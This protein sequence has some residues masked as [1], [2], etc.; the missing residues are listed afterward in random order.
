MVIFQLLLVIFLVLLNGFFVASEFA[1]VAI[2]KTRI[3]ELVKKGHTS[4]KLV[5][6]AINDL[7]SYISATQLGITLA[8]LALGWIGEPAIARFLEPLI[9]FLPKDAAFITAHTLAVIIAFSFI[10]FL[11]IVLG[12]LAPK[13]IALQSAEK[14]SLVIVTPLMIFTRIFKP[15]IWLLN[16]AGSLVLKIFGFSAPSGH[17]LVHSE[18]EIKIILSQSTE[19]GILEKQELEMIHKVL[20]LGDIPVR[21]IMIPRTEIKAI[22]AEITIKEFKKLAGKD[23]LSRYPIYKGTIDTIIGYIHE[24]DIY[25]FKSDRRDLS[26][27]ESGLIRR[28]INVPEV[29]RIDDVLQNM[30]K[31]RVH[32]AIVNDEYGGTLGIVT[33]EDILES[34]VGEIYDEFDKTETT[35]QRQADGKYIVDGLV[36]VQDIQKRFNV[37]IKG[38]GYVTIGGVVFGLL[39][40]EPK[41][42]DIIQIGTLELRVKE[43]EKK[44][45][46]TLV[47]S[48][49]KTK[50]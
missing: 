36:P 7:E 38:Q 39:G 37:P 26:L 49:I 24:R 1:L 29:Q 22:E 43:I 46:K 5:L 11:H 4:A 28:I 14:T 50:R 10:T 20:Q 48:K 3:E 8:S 25:K 15:V 16:G 32:M 47:L 31:N 30:R 27:L 33:L 23:T 18:E 44:R 40:R 12:E 19:G 17:Q 41:I 6:Q 2:R 13:S 35:I 45:I 21:D 42:G 34:I 9:T